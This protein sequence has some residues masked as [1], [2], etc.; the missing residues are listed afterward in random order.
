M[1]SPPRPPL[2]SPPSPT[3]TPSAGPRGVVVFAQ[4]PLHPL[5]FSDH[6][7]TRRDYQ[8]PKLAHWS[9]P[10]LPPHATP[11]LPQPHG[12]TPRGQDGRGARGPMVNGQWSLAN[13]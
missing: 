12:D 1:N 3:T 10:A 4:K 8:P 6:Y 7:A 2:R 9:C 13:G 11:C 5:A